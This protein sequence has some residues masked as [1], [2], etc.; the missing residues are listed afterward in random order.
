MSGKLIQVATHTANNTNTTVTLTGINSDD[1]YMVA[2][3]NFVPQTD[4]RYLQMRFTESGTPNITANYDQAIKALKTN[5]SF[6][7]GSYPN[8]TFAYAGVS[9]IG[10][11]TG[12]GLNGIYYI[13]NA[14][15]SSEYTFA[16]IESAYGNYL[17][18]F[19]GDAGGFVFTQNSAV[20]G[21]N[22]FLNDTGN[23][24]SG[25]FTLYKVL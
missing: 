15:N 1:V 20:D 5:T 16:T 22:F 6:G 18:Q 7:N 21:V 4:R 14:Y 25:T 11:S 9:T 23:I 2:V 17:A 12:E 10:S 8:Q 19:W 13:Y 3:S 24:A